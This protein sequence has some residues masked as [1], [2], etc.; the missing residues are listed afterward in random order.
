M[1]C[2]VGIVALNIYGTKIE[3][4]RI[5]IRRQTIRFFL[6][7]ISSPLGV[8]NLNAYFQVRFHHTLLLYK[9]QL[10]KY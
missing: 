7:F 5:V 8:F 2:Q 4:T 9:W 10:K 1:F 3:K 6:I